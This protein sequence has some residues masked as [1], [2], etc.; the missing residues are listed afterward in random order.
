VN[1][2]QNAGRERA[3]QNNIRTEKNAYKKARKKKR[4]LF[5]KNSRQLDEEA[6]I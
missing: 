4:R 2:E 1:E 5:R 3:I 6:L